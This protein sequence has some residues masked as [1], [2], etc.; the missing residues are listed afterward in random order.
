LNVFKQ[1]YN[2]DIFDRIQTGKN[3]FFMCNLSIITTTNFTILFDQPS[4]PIFYFYRKRR[5]GKFPCF[6]DYFSFVNY[7]KQITNETNFT[8]IILTS[9]SIMHSFLL[10]L[11]LL[12]FWSQIPSCFCLGNWTWMY[13]EN[14]ASIGGIYGEI[15]VPDPSN[16][17]GSRHYTTSAYDKSSAT[18]WMFGGNGPTAIVSAIGH[19]NDLWKFDG[20]YW[21]W[22]SGTN[23][24]EQK[25]IYGTKGEPS[26]SNV[27]GGRSNLVSWVDNE[28]SF[29]I[30]GGFGYDQSN[31][32]KTIQSNSAI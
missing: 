10:I 24:A 32:N 17:P 15:G 30:F 14:T 28:G 5:N 11:L 9:K 19:L 7:S 12:T 22:L 16:F 29:W 18:L 2:N 3:K 25:G 27:P 20:L 21:T 23:Q 4:H 13:G 1:K 6:V 26:Q 31:E 8:N